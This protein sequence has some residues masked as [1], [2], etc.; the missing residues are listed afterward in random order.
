VVAAV[1]RQRGE[2]SQLSRWCATTFYR[3]FKIFAGIDIEGQSDFKLL[4]RVV[5]DSLLAF[6][7][8]QKFFRGLVDWSGYECAQIP[9][10]VA[11]REGSV[12]RW[13]FLR[14]A[15][16]AVNNITSF[17]SAPLKL[18]T[19][20]G[21]LTLLIGVVFG[22]ISLYQKLD[23]IALDGFTTVNMLI[24]FSSGAM[25]VSLGIIGHYL[26]RIYDELKS[27]PLYLMKPEPKLP[28]ET[29]PADSRIDTV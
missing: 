14:L 18:V 17:S 13:S 3:L 12:S 2:E 25:M 1:K 15:R 5:V 8:K 6:S 24:I 16:Y 20:L 4:D 23:G 19:L 9:F 11:A 29:K 26:S 7:E 22:V 27:R 21:M 28:N 10:E